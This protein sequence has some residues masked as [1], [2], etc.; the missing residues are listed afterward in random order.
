MAVIADTD[1][2]ID[3]LAGR[4]PAA[5]AIALSLDTGDLV[6][7]A[8]S[9]FELL[10]GA[11][12]RKETRLIEALLAALP[13]LPL[14]QASA[15]KA[16]EVRRSAESEGRSMSFGDSLIAGVALNTGGI[17]LTGERARFA[18]IGGLTVVDL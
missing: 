2:L 18:H 10:A 1:V 4:E 15:E 12:S 16:S 9:R 13:T 3:F 11:R 14:N 8:I 6:V 5:S 17:I 7:T